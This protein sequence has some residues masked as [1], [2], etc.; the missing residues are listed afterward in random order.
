MPTGPIYKCLWVA[1][2]HSEESQC[3]LV[4][5]PPGSLD[6]KGQSPSLWAV[7]PRLAGLK[8]YLGDLRGSAVIAR[9]PPQIDLWCICCPPQARPYGGEERRNSPAKMYMTQCLSSWSLPPSWGNKLEIV[10]SQTV[11]VGGDP[12]GLKCQPHYK[13][14]NCSGSCFPP[15]W[16]RADTAYLSSELNEIIYLVE[17]QHIVN[18]IQ[19]VFILSLLQV[20]KLCSV[21]MLVIRYHPINSGWK[22]K[23]EGACW[24]TEEKARPVGLLLVTVIDLGCPVRVLHGASV[25]GNWAQEIQGH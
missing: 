2:G 8:G 3:C 5:T 9:L 4:E 25:Y 10:G 22:G 16:T 14:R 23:R 18:V 17:C 1:L 7:I 11:W 13:S 20:S 24:H 12:K 19:S 21:R 6:R 15:L